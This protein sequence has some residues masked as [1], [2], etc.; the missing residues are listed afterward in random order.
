MR[1]FLQSLDE[2]VWQAVEIG[3]TKPKEALVDWDEAKIKAANF[4]SRA[5]KPM[6]QKFTSNLSPSR[7]NS[8]TIR[9]VAWTNSA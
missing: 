1:V 5:L 4:N 3:W 8:P 9:C 2:K 7:Y 6:L